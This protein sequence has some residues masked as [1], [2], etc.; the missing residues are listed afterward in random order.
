MGDKGGYA[1]S[2]APTAWV[3]LDRHR[4]SGFTIRWKRGDRVA[5]VLNGHRVGDH[6]AVEVLGTISVVPHGWT[7]LAEV[8][9]LGRRWT[10]GNSA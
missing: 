10:Q 1:P 9:T 4:A 6:S 7:D 3:F 8:R 2:T 5:H